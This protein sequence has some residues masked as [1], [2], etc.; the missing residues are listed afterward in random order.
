MESIGSASQYGLEYV[1]NVFADPNQGAH[2]APQT[3]SRLPTHS[4]LAALAPPAPGSAPVPIISGYATDQR[5]HGPSV[6]R[7]LQPSNSPDL[8][9]VDDSM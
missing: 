3:P 7:Q 1:E 8:N 6:K 2:D 9:S 5:Q 4:A